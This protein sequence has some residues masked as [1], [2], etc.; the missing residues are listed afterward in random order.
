MHKWL[1]RKLYQIIEN[2]S[3]AQNI[4]NLY[5]CIWYPEKDDEYLTKYS[6][7]FHEHIGFKLIGKFEKCGYKFGKWCHMIWMWKVI[8]ELKEKP[9]PTI[10][11]PELSSEKLIE[12]G[13]NF[14]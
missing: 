5:A 13:L 2:I 10:P 9:E 3:K 8:N 4:I 11:F 6:A 12:L 7:Q 1:G 14:K